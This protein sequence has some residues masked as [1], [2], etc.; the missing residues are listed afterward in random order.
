MSAAKSEATR[1]EFLFCYDARMTNP[2][3]DPDENRPRIDP[4]TK[5][6]I[7][8]EFRLKRT[9]RDYLWKKFSSPKGK[10]S[11][12]KKVFI[13]AEEDKEGNLKRI[14]DL[15]A[16]YIKGN[17]VDADRLLKDHIDIRLFG[18]LFSVPKVSFKRIG[19]VQFA[20]GQSLN[21]VEEIPIRITR[22][23]PT[24]ED[25]QAGTFGEKSV[26]RYS[27]IVFHGF[28]N[29]IAA[30][31]TKLTEEDVSLMMEAMWHGTT[32]LSTSSKYGQQS[33]LLLR[34][35][36]KQP[37]AY[38][39]DLDRKLRLSAV[40]PLTDLG[41]AEDL[42]QVTLDVTKLSSAIDSNASIL[43]EI[44]FFESPDLVCTNDSQKGKFS[45]VFSKK[46]SLKPLS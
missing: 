38:I 5:T 30:K 9:V 25:A 10:F 46:V 44:D 13:R 16:P 41:K 42:S 40:P 34:F 28:L 26:L 39:G 4:L 35:R 27:F 14:D 45:E 15:G 21:P 11:E 23:V 6:N 43:S 3:G 1:S 17:E 8:P 12:G 20:I 31:D 2:N 29:D 37:L 32:N 33:R 7:V 36:Y 24:K 22:V 18:I 19:P